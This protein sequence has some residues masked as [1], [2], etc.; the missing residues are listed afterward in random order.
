MTTQTKQDWRKY[1]KDKD[2]NGHGSDIGPGNGDYQYQREYRVFNCDWNK[3]NLNSIKTIGF[4]TLF[5]L[6]VCWILLDIYSI[7]LRRVRKHNL[8]LIWKYCSAVHNSKK[9]NDQARILGLSK[10]P[11]PNICGTAYQLL[12]KH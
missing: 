6:S 11:R 8:T 10:L 12:L 3:K 4:K 9:I 5:L 1:S 2:G 7:W